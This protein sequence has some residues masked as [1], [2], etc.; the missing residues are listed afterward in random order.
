MA[1]AAAAIAVP[2]IPDR[3]PF[4]GVVI[5]VVVILFA[6]MQST[7]LALRVDSAGILTA[8]TV[9]QHRPAG[10]RW[11]EIEAVRVQC[12][13]R[14]P[15]SHIVFQRIAT[16]P[17]ASEGPLAVGT[18]IVGAWLDADRIAEAVRHHAPQVRVTVWKSGD[19][20]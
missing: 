15:L 19:Q 20:R 16:G 11:G 4:A 9:F 12:R 18:V 7:R 1:S 14:I 5:V 8:S 10:V 17:A 6:P 3:F 13:R 2:D